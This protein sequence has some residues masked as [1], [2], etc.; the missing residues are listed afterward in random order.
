MNTSVLRAAAACN[1]CHVVAISSTC[2]YPCNLS[3]FAEGDLHG[4]AP[5]ETNMDYAMSK[6][7]MHAHVD[8]L[9]SSTGWKPWKVLVPCNLYGP[10]DKFSAE[11]GHVVGGLVHKA[12]GDAPT[13]NV[14][15]TGRARRQLMH[16]DDFARIIERVLFD[17]AAPPEMICG[18]PADV[19]IADVAQIIAQAAGKS[20]SFETDRTDGQLRKLG[21]TAV[22]QRYLPQFK[23]TPLPE[24]LR[25]TLEWYRR[26]QIR[27]RGAPQPS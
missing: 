4:G 23:W 17:P 25:C 15:G 14:F 2:V 1:V 16:V 24:G 12:C 10:H 22:L 18:P 21:D 27:D 6:R 20:V 8:K 26:H 3:S 13:L 5:H 11:V 9:R 7:M 19:C